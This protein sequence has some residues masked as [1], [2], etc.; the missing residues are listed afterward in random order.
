MATYYAMKMT[1]KKLKK[2]LKPRFFNSFALTE[3]LRNI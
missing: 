2:N 3:T 1:N